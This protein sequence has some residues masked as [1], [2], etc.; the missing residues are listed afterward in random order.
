M[1]PVYDSNDLTVTQRRPCH[2]IAHLD[3]LFIRS[4]KST[5]FPT[6][7][8]YRVSIPDPR[9]ALPHNKQQTPPPKNK[10]ARRTWYRVVKATK[11]TKRNARV[12]AIARRTCR[13]SCP[14]T[15]CV[16]LRE[17][18]RGIKES[19]VSTHVQSTVQRVV[20]LG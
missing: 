18:Q 2:I 13:P 5:I 19:T 10:H 15:S 8:L 6:H 3:I 20:M 1:I 7:I 14:C 16:A 4:I 9:Y 11:E 17:P 12:Y